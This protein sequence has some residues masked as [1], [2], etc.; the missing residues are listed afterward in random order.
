M[1][2]FIGSNLLMTLA[3]VLILAGTAGCKGTKTLLPNV[4]GKAG[5]VMVVIDRDF[6]EGALGDEVRLLLTDEVP[7]LPQKEPLF[8]LSNVPLA[9]F[10]DLF[11]V[12]RNIL[13]LQVDPQVDST[14]IYFHKDV[15][16]SPQSVVQ[17]SSY[18]A[19]DAIGLLKDSGP[20]IVSF[21]EQ[22]ERDRVIGNALLYEE[23]SLAAP[24][25]HGSHTTGSS[26]IRM[27]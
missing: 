27:S 15:W 19:E 7:Y 14:G 26:S 20:L 25:S 9:G 24:I 18:T 17:V 13:L 2:R 8:N 6:W 12:H 1:R 4:S 23:H 22:A 11:R 21:F 10:S 16:A 3:A 5:E